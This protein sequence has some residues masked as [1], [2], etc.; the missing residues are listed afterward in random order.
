MKEIDYDYREERTEYLDHLYE[1][2]GVNPLLLSEMQTAG[3]VAAAKMIG[4]DTDDVVVTIYKE[5][6]IPPKYPK[7]GTPA[8]IDGDF[9]L[10]GDAY[11]TV[12]NAQ[13]EHFTYHCE[14]KDE[15]GRDKRTVF[16]I[17]VLTG[18]DNTN[19]YSPIGMLNAANGKIFIT[20]VSEFTYESRCVR[21]LQW[22]IHILWKNAPVPDGYLIQH[23]GKCG[24]CGRMLTTPE[25]LRSGYGPVCEGRRG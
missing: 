20:R 15:W 7:Y 12:S 23:A 19:H 6:P 2:S 16:F 22:A 13:G 14:R 21:V 3:Y 5:C 17:G 8:G 18:P 11:F 25:S 9:V 4:I 10:A 1:F 24:K